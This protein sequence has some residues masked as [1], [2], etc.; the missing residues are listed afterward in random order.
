MIGLTPVADP[1]LGWDFATNDSGR[2]SPVK[3][4][5]R[6]DPQGGARR[7]SCCCC[8]GRGAL[9][10]LCRSAGVVTGEK[11]ENLVS[12]YAYA[13]TSHRLGARKTR[14]ARRGEGKGLE[15]QRIGRIEIPSPPAFFISR[16]P[17]R[18]GPGQS[19]G[20]ETRRPAWLTAHR[21]RRSSK[22]DR[23]PPPPK[24]RPGKFGDVSR[25]RPHHRR[26]QIFDPTCRTPLTAGC[27]T[28]TTRLE[29]KG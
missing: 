13:Y 17:S 16:R 7:F 19:I 25:G 27:W 9:A 4:L 15:R 22:G 2:L 5:P 28:A 3:L 29:T 18:R 26:P 8:W 1:L 23:Q 11:G 10:C 24:S 6:V 21:S 14:G 20:L 12:Q